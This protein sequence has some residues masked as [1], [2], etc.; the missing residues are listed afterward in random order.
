MRL[1]TSTTK[2]LGENFDAFL[3]F[4][5]DVTDAVRTEGGATNE[6]RLGVRKASLFD[7]T[8]GFGRRPYLAGSFW[9]QTVVG[10][11]QD[12]TL[13]ALPP[14]RVDDVFVRP[15][16]AQDTLQADVT[17][18]NDTAISSTVHGRRRGAGVA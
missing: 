14:V 12:V 17:L 3:P 1:C 6:V 11:W 5:C 15:Q 2:K 9:G 4:E 10:I 8:R 13:E 7:D 16:V 18:R